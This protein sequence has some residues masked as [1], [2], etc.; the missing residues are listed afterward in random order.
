MK[1]V[2]FVP[3]NLMLRIQAAAALISGE[4]TTGE[5][6]SDEK[7]WSVVVDLLINRPGGFDSNPQLQALL[8][9]PVC[10]S[11]SKSL[12][13]DFLKMFVCVFNSWNGWLARAFRLQRSPR[14]GP[15]PCKVI[16]V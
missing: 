1:D 4:N 15:S 8:K 2:N 11:T 5:V 13:C 6:L 9:E 10:V 12:Y 7:A 14:T 16:I 3:V